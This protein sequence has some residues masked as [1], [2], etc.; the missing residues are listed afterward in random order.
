MKK[1]TRKLL[2]MVLS[3]IMI[4]SVVPISSFTA[5]AGVGN[6]HGDDLVEGIFYYQVS[7]NTAT[8]TGI[9]DES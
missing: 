7:E 6:Y 4:L 2:A 1:R 3:V 8:V 5:V 9:T